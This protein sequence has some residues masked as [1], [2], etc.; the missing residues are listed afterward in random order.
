M[1]HPS[2]ALSPLDLVGTANSWVGPA[3]VSWARL[4]SAE[5]PCHLMDIKALI[6]CCWV[7]SVWAGVFY[8]TKPNWHMR[9][10]LHLS[11]DRSLPSF[12]D[13]HT[14]RHTHT[15]RVVVVGWWKQGVSPRA[16]SRNPA[17]RFLSKWMTI[18]AHLGA[19]QQLW[20]QFEEAEKYFHTFCMNVWGPHSASA[21]ITDIRMPQC[22]DPHLQR[23]F[24]FQE[25]KKKKEIDFHRMTLLMWRRKR[26]LQ[27]RWCK[28]C[29]P[30]SHFCILSP[31]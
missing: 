31:N 10:E 23:T 24:S 28:W 29:H 27:L 6:K 4:G 2:W 21:A 5:L 7:K 19:C 11:I 14:H 8:T 9:K 17:L 13:T 3:L 26:S 25:K 22:M 12:T 1:R 30:D 20:A 15:R 16:A 18:P